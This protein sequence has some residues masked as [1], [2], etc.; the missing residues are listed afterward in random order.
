MI[1]FSCEKVLLQ[2]AINVATRAVAPKS[3]IPALEGLLLHV[4]DSLTVSGYNMSTGIRTTVPAD[5]GS[6]GDIVLNARLFGDIVRRM[7]DDIIVFTADDKLTVHVACGD[8]DFDISGISAADYPE[9]PEVED[10]YAMSIQQ[11]EKKMK[12][13]TAFSEKVKAIKT[14][15]NSKR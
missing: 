10:E 8:A 6:G 9:L 15:I 12:T 3:S 11:V 2:N 14:N 5:V 1:Q 7:P 4:G 13:D